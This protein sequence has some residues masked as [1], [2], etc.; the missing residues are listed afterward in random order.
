VENPFWKCKIVLLQEYEV[1]RS[2]RMGVVAIFVNGSAFNS[3]HKRI[4]HL[5]QLFPFFLAE[6][7]PD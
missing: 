1:S 7:L 4:F 3:G 5:W 6:H 2:G